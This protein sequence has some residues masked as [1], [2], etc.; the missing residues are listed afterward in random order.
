MTSNEIDKG[1]NAVVAPLSMHLE[2]LIQ[3]MKEL[4]ERNSIRSTE[5]NE[6]SEQSRSTGKRSDTLRSEL[7]CLESVLRL[8]QSLLEASGAIVL[9]VC[10][11]CLL[12]FY[13]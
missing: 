5:G 12:G 2:T 4:T 13:N 10:V 3:S 7:N 8:P 11:S 1:R 6:T 9:S